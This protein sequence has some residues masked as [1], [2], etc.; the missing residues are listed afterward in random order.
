M[1]LHATLLAATL[2][3]AVFLL[4]P[5]PAPA[6]IDSGGTK[7]TL[8]EIILE[9]RRVA[10]VEVERI[11]LRKGVIRCK[12]V[13]QIKGPKI[14]APIKQQLKLD[15]KGPARWQAVKPG[16]RA[17]FLTDCFDKRSLTFLEGVWYRT[18]PIADGWEK[19]SV[20]ADFNIVY[21]GEAAELA[22]TIKKLLRGQEVQVHCQRKADAA[23]I[24]LVRYSMR[25]PHRKALARDPQAPAAG[26]KPVSHWVKNLADRNAGVR[27]DAAQALAQLG[28]EAREAVP[29][30]TKALDDKDPEIRC[31]AVIA[32]G[33]VGPS[34]RVAVAELARKLSDSDWFVCVAAA[35]ALAKLGSAARS[36]IPALTK[37]LQP[38]GD[39]RQYR[40]IREG[41]VAQALLKIDPQGKSAGKAVSLLVDKLLG[42]DRVDSNGTRVVGARSLGECGPAARAA[43]PALVKR[44]KD[45]DGPVRV[46]SAMAL[47][48]IAPG[49]H[50]TAAVATLTGDL[51]DTDVLTRVLAADALAELGPRARA[52]RP[53]LEA[54]LKDPEGEVSKA[55]GRALKSLQ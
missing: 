32:L 18:D 31:A 49:Q 39:I 34:A 9:F 6:Y 55:A 13:E 46:A 38:N 5:A 53:A 21:A 37:A 19:G 11:D 7:I 41:A 17:V 2:T 28:A 52:A 50:T 1:K 27:L 26:S 3:L 42:D 12:V 47:V 14:T 54:A 24:Q 4:S 43:L 48:K 15:G 8:P 44:L 40:A 20:R 29:A 10:V 51:K 30:L 25:D 23:G 22:E 45:R 16:T 36:A 33:E 35:Q